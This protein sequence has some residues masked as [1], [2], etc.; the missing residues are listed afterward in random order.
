PASLPGRRRRACGRGAA[1]TATGPC[2]CRDWARR[3]LSSCSPGGCSPWPCVHA[4]C[5]VGAGEF[6]FGG[7]MRITFVLPAP[8]LSGGIRVLATYAERLL[9]RGHDVRAV[10]VQPRHPTLR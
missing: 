6:P 5:C 4:G 3:L 1:I 9:C 8:D 10:A 7:D 2:C